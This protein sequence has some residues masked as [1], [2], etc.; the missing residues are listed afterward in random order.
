MVVVVVAAVLDADD[1]ESD[2][3]SDCSCSPGNPEYRGR[4]RRIESGKETNMQR[5]VPE[6][7]VDAAPINTS[8]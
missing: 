5:S 8:E 7:T 6:I 4:K 1:D 3:A 2:S